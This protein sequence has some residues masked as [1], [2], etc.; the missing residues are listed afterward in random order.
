MSEHNNVT[1]INNLETGGSGGRSE[2]SAIGRRMSVNVY[3]QHVI[4]KKPSSIG[5]GGY[6]K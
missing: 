2:Q 4:N 5:W 1:L 3:E 6:G